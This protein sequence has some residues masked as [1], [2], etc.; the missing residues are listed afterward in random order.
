[1]GSV[2]WHHMRP[3]PPP[4]G[5]L[6]TSRSQKLSGNISLCIGNLSF[7]RALHLQNRPWSPP[8]LERLRRLDILHL[9]NNSIGGEIPAN[10]SGCSKLI[11]FD[12]AY[13]K[14]VGQLPVEFGY[15]LLKLQVIAFG[16]NKLSGTILAS[17]FNISTINVFDLGTNQIKGSIP[18][19]IGNALPNF[20]FVRIDY[21]QFMG[22]IPVSISNNSNLFNLE[23]GWN[24][25]TA[26]VPAL[27]KQHKLRWFAVAFN[28]LGSG[29]SGD[30]DFLY[31]LINAT[32]LVEINFHC[33]N[34]G[35][36]LT[37]TIGNLSTNLQNMNLNQ[38][39]ILGSIPYGIGNLINLENLLV[40]LNF[41]RL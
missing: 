5:R 25:L 30:L 26:G 31:S 1:M 9:H 14:L 18:S 21:N 8:E 39:Q 3:Q 19:E 13:I 10:L 35:G 40:L 32:S 36:M 6:V 38:N 20:E 16:A 23:I 7:L 28:N 34:F 15:S 4:E 17:I 37:E 22:Y 27:D 2:N 12:V 29:H 41:L 33:N 24:E 11:G